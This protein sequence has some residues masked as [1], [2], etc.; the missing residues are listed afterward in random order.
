[1][2]RFRRISRCRQPGPGSLITTQAQSYQR[3][4]LAPSPAGS[5]CQ[6]FF[7]RRAASSSAR[8]ARA[9]PRGNPVMACDREH[10]GDALFLQPSAQ[11]PVVPVDLIAGDPG[12]RHRGSDGALDH[13]PCQLRLGRERDVRGNPGV[14]S[15]VSSATSTAPGSPRCSIRRPEGRR[16]RRQRPISRE[17]GGAASRPVTDRRHARRWSSSSSAAAPPAAR[18]RKPAPSVA[19]PPCGNAPRPEPSAR[20]Y[21]LPPAR[22][23]AVA[24]GH[25]K[26]ITSRH[27]PG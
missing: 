8:R 11:R 7:G 19:A 15:P 24:S 16:A 22:V 12:E 14:T 10:V 27:K 25:Q 4:P 23:Y 9:G 2:A 6:A 26:I 3:C 5:R 1:M 20:Q 21:P 18:E 17:P 13:A